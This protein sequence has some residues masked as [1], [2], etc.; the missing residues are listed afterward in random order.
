M[1]KNFKIGQTRGKSL[2]CKKFLTLRIGRTSFWCLRRSMK[3]VSLDVSR[4]P[5]PL[6]PPWPACSH[7][8]W[9]ASAAEG[10]LAGSSCRRKHTNSLAFWLTPLKQSSGKLKSSRQMFRQVS[11]TL[12][13]RKGDTPLRSTYVSTPTLHVSEVR[14]MGFPRMISGAANSG[15]PS[16]WW[17]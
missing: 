16:N 3:E 11:S 5:A 2:L 10:R 13:S 12:S 14:E 4:T 6:P 7:C 1:R 9:R 8:S 17:M 15:F